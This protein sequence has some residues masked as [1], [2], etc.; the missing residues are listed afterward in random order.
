MFYVQFICSNV[1]AQCTLYNVGWPDLESRTLIM[2]HTFN[3]FFSSLKR[4]S[5]VLLKQQY[6]W[7]LQNLAKLRSCQNS[8]K[9]EHWPPPHPPYLHSIDWGCENKDCFAWLPFHTF[10]AA[11]WRLKPT[12]T[13]PPVVVIVLPP[14]QLLLKQA[15]IDAWGLQYC[16]LS[17][18]AHNLVRPNS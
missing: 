18:S 2:L 8:R 5:D 15:S 13:Y 17:F 10:L 11:I 12:T 16:M 3:D 7:T 4:S 1:I 6:F 14:T 9:V